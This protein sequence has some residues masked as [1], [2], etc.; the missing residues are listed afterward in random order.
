MRLMRRVSF[1]LA[2]EGYCL[3]SGGAEGAD[4]AFE[5]GHCEALRAVCPEIYLPW[6]DFN[7]R[8]ARR[9]AAWIDATQLSNYEQAREIASTIH[10][11]WDKLK[12]G[13]AALH[14]RN[15]YQVLGKDLASPSSFLLFWAMPV[16]KNGA[17]SGG[18]NTAVQLALRH[19]VRVFNLWQPDV[20]ARMKRFVGE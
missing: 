7:G 19:N 16:G 14:T 5:E 18:T 11:A 13:A 6:A 17:V 10:P 3:R 12:R 15:V 2:D 9:S 1:R 4:S 20:L 8:S